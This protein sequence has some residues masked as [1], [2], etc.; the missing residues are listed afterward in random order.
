MVEQCEHACTAEREAALTW[1]K[2]Q[3]GQIVSLQIAKW[4][5]TLS[6]ESSAVG[7]RAMMKQVMPDASSDNAD[8]DWHSTVPLLMWRNRIGRRMA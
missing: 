4:Q 2:E 1:V 8:S 7:P 5:C 6:V 3:W